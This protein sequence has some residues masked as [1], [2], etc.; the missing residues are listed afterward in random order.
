MNFFILNTGFIGL[1]VFMDL[2]FSDNE[3]LSSKLFSWLL[4]AMIT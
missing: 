4:F 1:L 3:V 2:V